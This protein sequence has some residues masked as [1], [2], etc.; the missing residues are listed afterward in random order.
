MDGVFSGIGL[1]SI[2][3]VFSGIGLTSGVGVVS[4]SGVASAS[5]DEVSWAKI[6][7]F[8]ELLSI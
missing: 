1:V 5:G 3:G 7:D 6:S 2:V 4:S 8:V